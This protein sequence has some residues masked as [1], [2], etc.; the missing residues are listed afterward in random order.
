MQADFWPLLK[1]AISH[2]RLEG[3][4]SRKE[5]MGQESVYAHYAWNMALSESLYPSMQGIEIALRNSLHTAASQRF[6]SE[7]WFDDQLLVHE[8]DRG[9]V[10]SAKEILVK[11]GK[12]VEPSRV[13]AELSFG[14]WTSLFDVRYEQ[15][16]WP[17]L[18]KPVFPYM[19]R[20]MRTRAELSR[21]LNKIRIMR[22]RVFHHEPI[23]YWKDME[24]QHRD[25]IEAISWINPAMARFIA[26]LDRFPN[27][28]S[29]GCAPYHEQLESLSV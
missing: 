25:L 9:F 14:F 21:R 16:L 5:M 15:R 10:S 6:G 3:Y 12:P 20:T 1:Q 7:K 24:R 4:S 28:A 2:E 22:N 18:L 27:V 29:K 19:P 8:R 13:I 17:W 23:W 26:M 11:S